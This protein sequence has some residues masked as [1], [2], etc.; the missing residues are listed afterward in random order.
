MIRKVCR[1]L[2]SLSP[3]AVFSPTSKPPTNTPLPTAT[4]VVAT[5]IPGL[6]NSPTVMPSVTPVPP[7]AKSSPTATVVSPTAKP[8]ATSSPTVKP[9]ATSSPTVKPSATSSPT[10]KPSATVVPPTAK[11]SATVVPPTAIPTINPIQ[12]INWQWISLMDEGTPSIVPN[13]AAYTL[14]FNSDGTLNGKADCNSFKGT[15]SQTNGLTIYNRLI[16]DGILRRGFIGYDVLVTIGQYGGRR[17]GRRRW[18]CFGDRRRR[19]AHDV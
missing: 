15:Y 19:T 10:A 5:V 1:R 16:H 11:P 13:P 6:T 7:T 14:I 17:T 4:R 2:P 8:S 3:T 9:S 18:S 12:N